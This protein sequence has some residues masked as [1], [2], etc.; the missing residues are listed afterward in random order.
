MNAVWLAVRLRFACGFAGRLAWNCG[1]SVP[2][3]RG[4]APNRTAADPGRTAPG[5]GGIECSSPSSKDRAFPARVIN[6]DFW[7]RSHARTRGAS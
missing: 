7:G 4:D 5:V 6:R 3:Y 1:G 2:P